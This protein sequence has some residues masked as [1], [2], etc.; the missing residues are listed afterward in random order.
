MKK[1]DTIQIWSNDPCDYNEAQVREILA[2][3]YNDWQR[4]EGEEERKPADF[5]DDEV[6]ERIYELIECEL[7]TV[8]NYVL[9][10]PLPNNIVQIA[11]AGRWYGRFT[12]YNVLGD[13]LNNILDGMHH[14][15][16]SVY[17]DRYNVCGRDAHHDA[18]NY[19]TF[20]VLKEGID[21]DEFKR[22]LKWGTYKK[23]TIM[24]MTRSL[25]PYI[26]EIYG[27]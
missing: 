20:R 11:D 2:D 16:Q 24:R 21:V 15:I 4:E 10:K 9:D 25:R 17:A 26:K 13:N 12:G 14:D 1:N 8:K 7:D 3:D 5:S 18:T 27:R 19:Y 6:Y 23:S 22:K